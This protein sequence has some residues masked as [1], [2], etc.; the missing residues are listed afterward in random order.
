MV[1]ES[2]EEKEHGGTAAAAVL[3]GDCCGARGCALEGQRAEAKSETAPM[4]SG[5]GSVVSIKLTR[6]EGEKAVEGG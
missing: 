3:G 6:A 4:S 5:M 2:D 1:G